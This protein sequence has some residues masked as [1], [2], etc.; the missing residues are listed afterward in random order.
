MSRYRFKLIATLA[1]VSFTMLAGAQGFKDP[2]DVPSVLTERAQSSL[3]LSIS[4][5][6]ARLVAVGEL[7]RIIVSEDEGRTWRQVATP[8]S[9]D[10]VSVFF[11]SD[12][13]GWVTGHGGVVLHTADGGLTWD[14]LIDGRQIEPLVRGFYQ[15]RFD[16]GDQ[17]AERFVSEAALNFQ[18]GPELPFLD[19]WFG[20]DG[21][22]FVVGGFGMILGT[23]DDGRWVAEGWRQGRCICEIGGRFGFRGGVFAGDIADDPINVLD[24][25]RRRVRP[26]SNDIDN[27][28]QR[29]V[30]SQFCFQ[31]L[32]NAFMI[33]SW[34]AE[35]RNSR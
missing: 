19:V 11:S 1:L 29:N 32:L 20:D 26:N 34:N 10:L 16:E 30:V 18:N 12:L 22:G 6:G 31:M 14:K 35:A 21:R 33:Q 27:R 15:R 8:V 7:G 24:L 13:T 2:L 3:M 17:T 5:A 25:L 23:Q 28:L 4:K 9:V